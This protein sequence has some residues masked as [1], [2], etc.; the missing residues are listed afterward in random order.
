MRREAGPRFETRLAETFLQPPGFPF[1][2]VALACESMGRTATKGRLRTCRSHAGTASSSA[3][4]PSRPPPSPAPAGRRPRRQA[5]ATRPTPETLVIHP[6]QHASFVMEAPGL[7]IDVD[8][9]GG[10][11]LY[12]GLPPAGPDPDNPRAFRSL[13]PADDRSPRRWRGPPADQPVGLRKAARRAQ[14]TGHRD[15]Q[16]RDHDGRGPHDRR[17]AGLQHHPR[18]APVPSQGTGQRLCPHHRRP[19]RLHRRRH[20]GH[21]RDAGARPTSTSPSCR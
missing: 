7:V 20:R 13:R 16:R 3:A 4:P 18:P 12:E 19:A 11:A 1:P 10:A 21:A 8:P 5:T 15:R 6:V 17:R 14:G 9:V 2:R